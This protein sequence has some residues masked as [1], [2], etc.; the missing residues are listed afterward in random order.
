[1]PLIV[2]LQADRLP[3]IVEQGLG[4][5]INTLGLTLGKRTS[6][7]TAF[8]RGFAFI[9]TTCGRPLPALPQNVWG[10]VPSDPPPHVLPNSPIATVMAQFWG[11][12]LL[13]DRFGYRRAALT[14]VTN[15]QIGRA[16]C[17]ER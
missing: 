16:S 5:A 13:L 17:R 15:C 12:L 4:S 10:G 7:F 11:L 14:P 2:A 1:M 6:R 8:A 9:I 3:S